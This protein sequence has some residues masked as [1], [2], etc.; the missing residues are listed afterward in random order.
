MNEL[1]QE[2]PP[3]DTRR[4]RPRSARRQGRGRRIARRLFGVGVFLAGV[5][6][7]FAVVAVSLHLKLPFGI[8]ATTTSTTAIDTGPTGTT[9]STQHARPKPGIKVSSTTVAS[10]LAPASR[11]AAVPVGTGGALFLGG[12]SAAGAAAD[13]IQTLAGASVQASGTLPIA[14]ASAVAATIN[15]SVYLFGGVGSTIYQITPTATTVVGSL[16]AATADAA[17]ATVGGT[18]YIIGGYTGTTELDTIVAYTPSGTATVVATLPTPL[19]FPTATAAGGDVYISGGESAGKAS[20]TVYRFDPA[21]K[22]VTAFTSL[23]VARDREAAATLDGRVVVMG[24][25]S[26]SSGLRTRAI[27]VINVHDAKVHLG[28]LLPVA[29]SDAT[30]VTDHGEIL[31]AGGIDGSGAS[32]AAIYGI[33]VKH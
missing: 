13:T 12:Y 10:L 11:V 5:A 30:A 24:G 23:P 29:L 14:D 9:G 3:F 21:T 20:A 28:G 31:V 33:T 22:S 2:P 16:P 19:R 32:T 15:S 26:T 1:D 6:A 25:T 7:I 8:N 27:Y 4:R 18:A 17:I